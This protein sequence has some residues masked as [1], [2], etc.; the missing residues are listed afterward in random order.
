[1]GASGQAFAKMVLGAM[2]LTKHGH[3]RNRAWRREWHQRH[4]TRKKRYRPP[5]KLTPQ[6]LDKLSKAS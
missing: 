1:M 3:W 4:F 5:A 2:S 6:E